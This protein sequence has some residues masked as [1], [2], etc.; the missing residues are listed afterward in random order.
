MMVR[1][2]GGW[3]TLYHYLI[4]HDSGRYTPFAQITENKRARTAHVRRTPRSAVMPRSVMTPRSA[5]TL[6]LT[7]KIPM[8]SY[9]SRFGG[10]R[11][12]MASVTDL[13]GNILKTPI[14]V[15]FIKPGV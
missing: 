14:T 12:L 7:P 15:N 4:T 6:K 3:D 2:G 9:S 1:V 10:K 11:K 8:T 13:D 5:A